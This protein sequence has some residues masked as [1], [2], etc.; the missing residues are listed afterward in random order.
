MCVLVTGFILLSNNFEIEYSVALIFGYY[1]FIMDRMYQMIVF[2]VLEPLAQYLANQGAF[3]K[4]KK[5]FNIL[6]RSNI[7]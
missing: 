1:E 5:T 7:S 4:I 3:R 2:P 6:Y